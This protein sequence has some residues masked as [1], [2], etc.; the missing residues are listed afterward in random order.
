MQRFYSQTLPLI[1]T[2]ALPVLLIGTGTLFYFGYTHIQ[3]QNHRNEL[4]SSE[5]SIQKALLSLATSTLES[6]IVDASHVQSENLNTLALSLG[7]SINQVEQNISKTNKDLKQSTEEAAL[8]LSEEKEK[9]ASLQEETKK[10]GG[11]VGDLEKL[12]K[13]DEELLQKYS[14]V[15]FLNEHYVPSSLS[16]IKN[17][18]LYSE[19]KTQTIHTNV[20]P[21]L[22]EMIDDA[23][24]E[25]VIIY[26]KSAYRGFNEQDITKA[27]FT[28]VFGEDS[29][30]QFSADQGYSEHQ[31][32]TTIDLITPGLGGELDGFYGTAA[33]QW[34]VA[35]AHNYGFVMSYPQ[36]NEF[37]VFEPWHWRFVGTT[38]ATQLNDEDLYFYDRSQHDLNSYLSTLFD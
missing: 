29:A 11:T 30:N 36:N 31:L 34:L 7:K 32:G 2:I 17:D 26:V 12:S 14:K 35:N 25:G 38:L 8:A 37:Y 20:L 33:H 21:F 22:T 9:L 24:Q 16:E 15:F 27:T 6:K 23:K 1:T 18:Y 19:R 10:I 28:S 5:L 13:V 4:L 3:E